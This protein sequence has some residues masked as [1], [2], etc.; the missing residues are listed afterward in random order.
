MPRQ[1]TDGAFLAKPQQ[2]VT[3][4]GEVRALDRKI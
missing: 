3:N 2:R 1:F 4:A